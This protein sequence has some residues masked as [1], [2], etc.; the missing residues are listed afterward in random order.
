MMLNVTI[1]LSFEVTHISSLLNR[2][3]ARLLK[4]NT[5]SVVHTPI[6]VSDDG[7]LLRRHRDKQSSIQK[8]EVQYAF[9][10][11]QV[12]HQPKSPGPLRNC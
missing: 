2:S 6:V 10:L 4:I 7:D 8:L 3:F 11:R 1:G 5:G 9:L 12:R